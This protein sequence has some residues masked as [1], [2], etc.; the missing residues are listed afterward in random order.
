MSAKIHGKL[1]SLVKKVLTGQTE[2]IEGSS[3]LLDFY[4]KHNG[5]MHVQ[6]DIDFS[7]CF[8]KG[9]SVYC[10]DIY[11]DG[12][13]KKINLDLSNSVEKNLEKFCK[14]LHSVGDELGNY[15]D[16]NDYAHVFNTLFENDFRLVAEDKKLVKKDSE[17]SVEYYFSDTGDEEYQNNITSMSVGFVPENI[18]NGFTLNFYKNIHSLDSSLP[19]QKIM[20]SKKIENL[21]EALIYFDIND[22]IFEYI[23]KLENF[24]TNEYSDLKN[25]Y[26]CFSLNEKS[27]DG[28]FVTL[29]AE[30]KKY[31]DENYVSVKYRFHRTITISELMSGLDTKIWKMGVIKISDYQENKSAKK[32]LDA[33]IFD[34]IEIYDVGNLEDVHFD[35]HIQKNKTD[36][37][38]FDDDQIISKIDNFILKF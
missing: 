2:N 24:I 29:Y 30:Q 8:R 4:G 3:F 35:Y 5:T 20:Y 17:I 33:H 10:V 12:Y 26:A 9:N 37:V 36:V 13:H 18:E 23:K 22:K 16:K 15:V 21:N 38:I 1:L 6:C 31:V 19:N 7:N 27:T 25:I 32:V 28:F 14:E 11:M 34:D